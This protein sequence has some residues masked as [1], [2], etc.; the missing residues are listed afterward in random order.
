MHEDPYLIS[1]LYKMYVLYIF[2]MI[3]FFSVCGATG[4]TKV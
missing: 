4:T 1:I 3:V 2:E